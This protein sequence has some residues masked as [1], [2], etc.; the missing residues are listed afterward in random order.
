[1]GAL[2]ILLFFLIKFNKF[3]DNFLS[4]LHFTMT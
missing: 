1:M 2:G 4:P 3:Y